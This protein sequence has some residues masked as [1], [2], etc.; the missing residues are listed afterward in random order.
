MRALVQR[1]SRA[2]VTVDGE[3]VAEIG[4]GLLVLVGVGLGD[5]AA[6][7]R[8]LGRRI[9]ELRIFADDDGKTNRSIVDV[10]GSALVVSQFT[11]YADTRRGRRPSFVGAAD[12][13]VAEELYGL[14]CDA[15]VA[16]GVSVGRGRFGEHMAVELVNDGPFTLW[17][18]TDTT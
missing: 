14:L 3:V 18:D 12:P 1:V 5:D 13:N 15:L 6:V 7:A 11:L 17:L 2:S 16:S 9:A 8:A 10:G 4:H